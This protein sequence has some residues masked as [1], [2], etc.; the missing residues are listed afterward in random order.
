M[1]LLT[2]QNHDA[3]VKSQWRT[4]KRKG[5]GPFFTDVQIEK[6]VQWM[7]AHGMGRRLRGVC[8]GARNG[9]ECDVFKQY[10]GPKAKVFGTDLF[11]YSGLSATVPTQSKVIEWDFSK[12]QRRWVGR[13]DF[14]YS[15]SLDHARHPEETLR[16]WVE[17]LKP[18][19]VLFVCWSQWH[20]NVRGGDCFGAELWEYIQLGDAVGEVVDLLY[21]KAGRDRTNPLR[22]RCVV[23]IVVAIQPKAK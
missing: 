8:H 6:S 10:L 1:K 20:V 21:S 18:T 12:Q 14:V 23:S 9:I 15:N 22:R 17:Q 3:Y 7:L 13:F 2:F 5:R 16:V 11:P 19:G 4:V